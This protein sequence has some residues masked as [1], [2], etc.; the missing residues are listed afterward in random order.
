[1]PG[2]VYCAAYTNAFA[3]ASVSAVLMRNFVASTNAANL[4]VVVI[5]G[6]QAAS[7]YTVYCAAQSASGTLMRLQSVLSSAITITTDCCNTIQVQPAASSV[8]EASTVR[9]FVSLV[10][11]VRPTSDMRLALSLVDSAGRAVSPAPLFPST[12]AIAA[13]QVTAGEATFS[14][15]VTLTSTL[16]SLPAGTYT[17]NVTLSGEASANYD[18]EFASGA[19]TLTV[20]PASLP[21][22]APVLI[23]AQF[24]DDGSYIA[25]RFDSNTNKGGVSSTTFACSALLDFACA[26]SSRCT[27]ASSRTIQAFVSTT[28]GCAGVSSAVKL[29]ASASIKAQCQATS[30]CDTSAWASADTTT[31]VI[32]VAPDFAV[33]PTVVIKAPTTIGGCSPLTLDLTGSFGNGGRPWLSRAI[34]VDTSATTNV[35]DLLGFLA[36]TYTLSSPTPIPAALLS[37][38]NTYSFVVKLC[39]FLGQCSEASRKVV[40]QRGAVPTVSLDGGATRTIQR[41]SALSISSD[42]FYTDCN[43][44]MTRAGLSYLW[45][46]SQAGV[47]IVGLQSQS[48]DPSK[49]AIAANTLVPGTMYDVRLQVTK[50]DSLLSNSA[51][52]QVFVQ[53]GAVRAVVAQ[54]TSR[55]VRAGESL[56][57]DASASFDEDQVGVAGAAAGLSYVWSCVQLS[58]VLR[59]NCDSI[60]SGFLYDSSGGVL[61]AQAKSDAVNAVVQFTLVVQEASKS[62]S[63][64][65]VI[66]VNIVPS[67]APVVSLTANVAVSGV[68]NSNQELRLTGTVGLAAALNG[69][70]TWSVDD[71]S[72]FSLSAA[73]KSPLAVV[74]SAVSTTQL[75]TVYMVLSANSLPG[76]STLTFALTARTAGVTQSSVAKVVVTVNAA[77]IVGAFAVTPLSGTEITDPFTFAASEWF[78]DNLPLQYQFAQVSASGVDVTLRSKKESAFGTSA[79]TAGLKVNNYT[80]TCVV[81]VFDSLAASTRSTTTVSVYKLALTGSN[82][83]SNL[84]TDGLS[85]GAASADG[86]K[87]ATSLGSYLLNEMDCSSAPDCVSLNRKA[88]H[89]TQDT[90]GE[91]ISASYIGEPGDS[92]EKCVGVAT[93]QSR[94][95][96]HLLAATDATFGTCTSSTDCGPFETCSGGLCVPQLKSC[97][98]NCSSPRGTCRF[99]SADSADAVAACFVGA[100]DC[101]AVCHC[102]DDYVGSSTCSLNS[103]ELLAKQVMRTQVI[104]GVASLMA[105]EDA[106]K[107]TVEGWINA[108]VASAQVADELTPSSTA[109]LLMLSQTILAT[110]TGAGVSVDSVTNL[111]QAAD[112]IAQSHK[113]DVRRRRR[114]T[115]EAI[116]SNTTLLVLQDTLGQFQ[117]FVL[118]NIL[119]DQDAVTVTSPQFRLHIAKLSRSTASSDL[120]L[121]LPRSELEVFN[122]HPQSA[123]SLP[124]GSAVVGDD[125][126]IAVSLVAMRAELLNAARGLVGTERAF[127]NPLS[128]DWSGA[129]MCDDPSCRFE[130]ILQT[131]VAFESST[132]E[133]EAPTT[134]NTTCA[135]GEHTTH[136]YTCPDSSVLAVSCPGNAVEIVSRCNIT[137][138]SPTC[139]G[140]SAF[141]VSDLGCTAVSRS[142]TNITCSCPLSA[143][144]GRRLQ[145]DD[146]EAASETSVSYVAMLSEVQHSFVDTI[147]SAQGLD[148]SSVKEGWSAIVTVGSLAAALMFGLLW[149]HNADQ[150]MRKTRPDKKELVIGSTSH[151]DAEKQGFLARWMFGATPSDRRRSRKSN[152][153]GID[154]DVQF[155]EQALPAILRSNQ[156]SNRVTDEI[157]HHHKYLGIVFFFSTSFPRTLRVL[158]LAMNVIIMLFMQSLTYSLTNPDDGLCETYTTKPECLEPSSPYA[159]GESKCYWT[160]DTGECALAEPDSSLRVILFVA[161]FS[162]L[163]STPIALAVDWV[164][165]S[166]LAAPTKVP[167]VSGGDAAAQRVQAR[168]SV[169]RAGLTSSVNASPDPSAEELRAAAP[170]NG[171]SQRRSM[172]SSRILSVGSWKG[173][174]VGIE[175][176]MQQNLVNI[177]A[178]NDLRA[179]IAGLHKYRDS[180]VPA[181]RVEFDSKS[182]SMFICLCL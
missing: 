173:S 85:D 5:S 149:A 88:C 166:V 76:R 100:T 37:K 38:G 74:V 34:T 26:A 17:Y 66:T 3:P 73:A 24:A 135:A 39:N 54:G 70:V 140:V 112:S 176:D 99:V 61:T 157:K 53:P 48:K 13:Q 83:M 67:L 106:D 31:V 124:S 82:Q 16:L 63:A 134:F 105:L 153:R 75:R 162:A 163:V 175:G 2:A 59:D 133:Q 94:G 167:T 21:L 136:N 12:F 155:A 50:L 43:N 91:C 15:V 151:K 95:S 117:S 137:S 57:I 58:P 28:V 23:S 129:S 102:A 132:S 64:Q 10:L 35:T 169:R 19:D 41:S 114:L 159:T 97:V 143:L 179:L 46:V 52:A 122:N 65:S 130:L 96:R 131:S 9:D 177:S 40:V 181:E 182:T 71:S 165:L 77:P 101:V 120:T 27:W 164:I 87:R 158:S 121:S 109:L 172:R 144:T 98:N 126:V 55:S 6:L 20:L 113:Y 68:F 45:T 47:E 119:P 72:G 180:L 108:I 7:T 150:D 11:P 141:G 30:E 8:T 154:K 78:D 80:V 111:L 118:E 29:A 69:T 110:A 51:S 116:F 1:M 178:Q 4:S 86:L 14:R 147:I 36:T 123:V 22:P 152:T 25:V 128:V 171:A 62:R 170:V 81:T 18:I 93:L 79:L 107:Q 127:S 168:S 148:T 104:E 42:A 174:T 142:P 125:D 115:T 145:T 60:L 156:L 92:N 44:A 56:S 103:T 89:R 160:Q 49:L 139:S 84:I 138:F 146:G 90:C 33:S 161:I 32:V